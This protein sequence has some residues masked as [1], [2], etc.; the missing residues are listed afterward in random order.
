[1]VP[2]LWRSRALTRS[3]TAAWLAGA[4]SALTYDLTMPDVATLPGFPV[5]ARLTA[6]PNDAA[7]S[8]FGFTGQG[9]LDLRPTLGMEFK[10]A[11]RGV[12]INVP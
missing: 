7:V 3:P 8:G 6:G 9:I 5:A 10:A 4:G 2:M 12:V 11:S 1:M